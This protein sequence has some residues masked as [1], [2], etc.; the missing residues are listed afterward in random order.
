MK[1]YFYSI[2]LIVVV[3]SFDGFFVYSQIQ[4]LRER[5]YVQTD[6][7]L[8]LSGEQIL[9][10]IFTVDQNLIPLDFSKVAYIELVSESNSNQQIM[11]ELKNGIG[12]GI[13]V[14]PVDLPSGYYRLIAYTQ[15]MRNEVPIV[16]FEKNIAV[17]NTFQ[18]EYN[19]VE[20]ETKG[21]SKDIEGLEIVKEKDKR[22]SLHTDET[23][24]TKRTC[25]EL[26]LDGLPENIH[27]LSVSIV[28]NNLISYYE[29]NESLFLKNQTKEIKDFTSKFLPE[30]EGHIVIG[31]IIDN[32]TEKI[33][34]QPS[35]ESAIG[36]PGEEIRF[37]A[38]KNRDE[39]E[40]NF[41]TT[42][43]SGT[44]EIATVVYNAGDKYR[45]DIQSPYVSQYSK[46]TM[47]KLNISKEEHNDL[48]ARSV[49]LQVYRYFYE[50]SPENQ[51]I[52]NSYFKMEPSFSY[53]LDE[54]TRFT[55]MRE[56][57]IEFIDGARFRKRGGKQ[58][59]SVLTN[60]RGDFAYGTIPLVMLDGVP[61]KDHDDIFNYDPLK[62]EKIDIF[63]GTYSM[64]GYMFDGIV[65]LTTYSKKHEDMNLSKSSQILSYEGPQLQYNFQTPDY[66]KEIN[67]ESQIPDTRHTLLW[68]PDIKTNGNTNII[69]PFNTSDL[70]GE[71]QVIVEGITT[72]G[73]FFS[74]TT[75]FIVQ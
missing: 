19:I 13:I 5:I 26:I 28:G 18:S 1:K 12:S 8:Y 66:S 6:K 7:K 27:T 55:T 61:I 42:G 43:I 75:Y 44:K 16:F 47:P 56:V 11:V 67:R 37:F 52:S 32:Q 72:K 3:Y 68:K 29:S 59:L 73:Q 35:L 30:Y 31:K 24:Y 58:E 23:I 10:K 70:T 71:F 63:M 74:E 15:F 54:Y 21:Y 25:G 14:L 65:K 2:F 34:H 45:I 41:F 62:V 60:K 9:I 50:D 17:I 22:I 53:L 33:S 49:A 51:K 40:I 4:Q 48:L 46:K 69:I 64:G 38:G 20:K 36:F 57:F 39:G